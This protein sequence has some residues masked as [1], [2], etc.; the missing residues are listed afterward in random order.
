RRHTR[1]SRDWSSDVCSS[2]LDGDRGPAIAIV[3][4]GCHPPWSQWIPRIPE[5]RTYA[6]PPPDLDELEDA[7]LWAPDTPAPPSFVVAPIAR[8]EER[9]VGK[10]CRA[11]RSPAK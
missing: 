3:V 1:F 8:S 4:P 11:K 10:E 5:L 2:D 7:I 9:R 6:L